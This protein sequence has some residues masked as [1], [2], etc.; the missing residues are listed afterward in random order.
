MKPLTAAAL[1][2]VASQAATAH[3]IGNVIAHRDTSP[4]P[5][6]VF[7]VHASES[8]IAKKA[9]KDQSLIEARYAP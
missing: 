7:P 5:P 2:A 4:E 1:L 6:T 9:L 8:D 3:T